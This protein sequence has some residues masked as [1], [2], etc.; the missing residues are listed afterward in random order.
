MSMLV[1]K[2]LFLQITDSDWPQVMRVFPLLD[3]H[4]SHI[5]DYL[6]YFKVPYCSL[7]D[8]GYTSLGNVEN[9]IKNP[10]LLWHDVLQEKKVYLPAYKLLES[11]KERNGRLT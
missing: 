8:I 3:W 11:E 9:T 4:Y 6:L 1:N 7:Y 10:S 5:W 2:I